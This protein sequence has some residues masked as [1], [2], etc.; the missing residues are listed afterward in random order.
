[1]TGGLETLGLYKEEEQEDGEEEEETNKSG[2]EGRGCEEEETMQS[3]SLTVTHHDSGAN[4]P[5][6]SLPHMITLPLLRDCER[7]VMVRK[8]ILDE[9]EEGAPNNISLLDCSHNT[10][11]VTSASNDTSVL[12]TS[13]FCYSTPEMLRVVGSRRSPRVLLPKIKIPEFL[14]DELDPED[15]KGDN[16]ESVDEVEEHLVSVQS[17]VEEELLV[18]EERRR[19]EALRRQQERKKRLKCQFFVLSRVQEFSGGKRRQRGWLK[20][21]ARSWKRRGARVRRRSWPRGERG[22]WRGD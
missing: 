10:S 3:I 21:R 18:Y 2:R 14:E 11:Q 7:E 9:E 6:S 8:A 5:P 4:S 12:E 20:M 19:E 22:S 15:D 13:L 17:P 1:M 16:D